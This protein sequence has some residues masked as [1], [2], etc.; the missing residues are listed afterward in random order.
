M[1]ST[2]QIDW[3]WQGKPLH[4]GVT[5]M[6]EGPTIL[7]LPALSSISTREEMR[8]LQALLATSYATV[9][10]DWPGFGDQPKPFID[11]RPDAYRAFLDHVLTQ[12][13]P[14]P[15]ATVAVGHAASY[16]LQQAE[17]AAGST[18]ALCLIAPTWRGP[19][20]TMSGKPAAA[21]EWFVRLVDL[22]GLGAFVY[23]LNVN[24][25]VVLMM[26]RGHVY[27]NPAFLTPQKF[28]E[29][30]RVTRAPGARH[31]SVRFVSG[32]LDPARSLAA[33]LAG[34]RHVRDPILVLY[35]ANTPRKSRADMEALASLP[36]VERRTIPRGKLAVQ[37]EEP[38]GVEAE[39]RAFLRGRA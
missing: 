27:A 3:S 20:P 21:F 22:K 12:V 8:P 13:A 23:A 25:P 15:L 19:L 18:G 24:P 28:A 39:I 7:L 29:K 34:A 30:L 4:M 16:A 32:L 14:K 33:F 2:S 17:A 11:W 5:R 6:G 1:E 10:V 35:G 38:G 31:A 37:E 9:S 26:A 36:N